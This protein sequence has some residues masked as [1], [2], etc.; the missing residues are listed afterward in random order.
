MEHLKPAPIFQDHMMLQRDKPIHI[1]G[2]GPEDAQITVTLKGSRAVTRIQ[3]HQW[4]CILPPQTASL[5]VELFIL[6]DIPGYPVIKISDISIGDIWL[7]G[8]QSNMEYFLRYDAHWD[9]LK[10]APVNPYIR[11]YNVPRISFEGQQ[12]DISDS[13]HWF[14]EQDH[15]WETF[16]APAYCFARA[17]QPVLDIPVGIIGCN[18]GGSPACSWVSEDVL[19]N[20]PMLS[21]FLREYEMEYKDKD[22]RALRAASLQG[23]AY[24]DSLSHQEE[25]KSMM[26]GL[27]HQEQLAWL[28]DHQNDPQIPMG[29]LHMW[30]P[31]GLYHHMLEPLAPF[32]LKGVLWYQGESDSGHASL[33]DRMFSSLITC[34][35]KLWNDELPFLFVQLAPF[36]E[37]LEC[38]SAGYPEIRYRQNLVSKTVPGAYMTSIMDLGMYWDIH[39]KHKKEVGERLALL[40]RGKIYGED[41]LCEPVQY[42]SAKRDKNRLLLSFTN[43]GDSLELRGETVNALNIQIAEGC[44]SS[45]ETPALKTCTVSSNTLILDFESLPDVPV[46]IEF[47]ETGYAE[48]NLFNSA[49]LPVKPFTCTV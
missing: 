36:G 10:N 47:A 42:D 38:D 1:W 31:C 48:V 45:Y 5:G 18:Y 39:P 44:S 32:S 12:K 22:P 15:A 40:A 19:A 8:G 3:D 4:H 24:E 13:G 33:Y 25:W 37:W 28:K 16:S 27:S 30:R 29:P 20:D 43:T 6:C 7:A 11:M 34:W 46:T 14:G 17:L 35:R 49:G 9:E 2:Q 21:I 26:Y 41:I 23:Y